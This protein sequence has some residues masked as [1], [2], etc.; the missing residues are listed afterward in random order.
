MTTTNT[1][2]TST[3]QSLT[4]ILI[5]LGMDE[6]EA[7]SI[8]FILQ[9]YDLDSILEDDHFNLTTFRSLIRD[10]I[11]GKLTQNVS[12]EAIKQWK[13]LQQQP[14][15]NNTTQLETS[16]TK[17]K[18][19]FERFTMTKDSLLD[20]RG[21][22]GT[23]W[24]VAVH[25]PTNRI[26][27]AGQD[28]HLAMWNLP[29]INSGSSS[30]NNNKVEHHSTSSPKEWL[31]GHTG[32]ILCVSVGHHVVAT[33][34]QFHELK[35][36]NI[37]L[38]ESNDDDDDNTT[39]T[40]LIHHVPFHDAN[41]FS[42]CFDDENGEIL[43]SGDASGT[44]ILSRSGSNK[45]NST[46]SSANWEM[47]RKC[48][49]VHNNVVRSLCLFIYHPDKDESISISSGSNSSSSS[50]NSDNQNYEA[51][52]MISGGWDAYIM[53]TIVKITPDA[54]ISPTFAMKNHT[55]S[56]SA[57]VFNKKHKRIISCGEDRALIMSNEFGYAIKTMCDV[58]GS[59]FNMISSLCTWEDIVFTGATD[60][61]IKV[62]ILPE[63]IPSN[64][65]RHGYNN[66]IV[67]GLQCYD[68]WLISC[69]TDRIIR[70]WE[71]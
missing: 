3:T 7:L 32:T 2:S 48:I 16:S 33:G 8:S 44:V 62:W 17:K 47:L 18:S 53:G 58:H 40:Q 34:G 15:N 45:N 37:P 38:G 6:N 11:P 55:S 66:N 4:S 56:V 35:I 30:S 1:F 27:S 22:T 59:G 14:N 71:G 20:Y 28:G 54:Y 68:C 51:Y 23:I 52:Y 69:G 60:G 64:E 61:F 63:L 43:A 12:F 26:Y 25:K 41:V 67:N 39:T 24:A 50:S 42:L 57:I 21:H 29:T 5:K 10:K 65:F 9:Q 13:S 49:A 46:S 19:H 70:L 31:P 36:W